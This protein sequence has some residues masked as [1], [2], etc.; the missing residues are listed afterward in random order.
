MVDVGFD[1]PKKPE[2]GTRRIAWNRRRLAALTFA[3]FVLC[4]IAA[5]M[6]WWFASS[7]LSTATEWGGT[8]GGSPNRGGLASIILG[9]R[10][11]ND[12]RF[13]VRVTRVEA[14]GSTSGARLQTVGIRASPTAPRVEPF[15]P[16]TLR[17][18]ER[19]Y[20]VLTY[21]ISCDEA[22]LGGASLGGIGIRY[23]VFGVERT[24][25]VRNVSSAP[26]LSPAPACG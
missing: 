18:G 14:E 8:R 3:A 19:T 7:P 10:S 22:S 16:L 21:R 1:A 11:E 20:V 15:A 5:A 17:P 6:V 24:E 26:E 4:T 9:I 23:E 12:G 25:H 13:D 2:L